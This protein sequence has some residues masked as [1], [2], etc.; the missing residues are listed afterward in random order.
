MDNTAPDTASLAWSEARDNAKRLDIIEKRQELLLQAL[1][2]EWKGKPEGEFEE[3]WKACVPPPVVHQ[4]I[5]YSKMPDAPEYAYPGFR[6]R[7]LLSGD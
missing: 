4:P 2:G 3:A 1:H 5:D 6:R 7:T